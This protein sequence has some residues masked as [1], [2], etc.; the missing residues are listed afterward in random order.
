[1]VALPINAGAAEREAWRWTQNSHSVS[2]FRNYLARFP[3]GKHAGDAKEKIDR[4]YAEAIQAYKTKAL[5]ADPKAIAAM[6]KVVNAL[7]DSNAKRIKITYE[8]SVD[9]ASLKGL[10]PKE[11]GDVIPPDQAFDASHNKTRESSI[12]KSLRD[13]FR[14]VFS[15]DI[16]DFDDGSYI[17]DYGYDEYGRYGRLKD[18]KS[19]V[20]FHIKYVVS[21]SGTLYES[22]TGKKK[23]LYGILFGWNFA[24]KIGEASDVYD[25]ATPSAPAKNIRYTTYGDYEANSDIIPYTKMAESAFDDF[26]RKLAES[27]GVKVPAPSDSYGGGYGGYG[28]YGSGGYG[29]YG[30]SKYG[31]SGGYGSKYGSG[32]TKL[33]PEVQRILDEAMR[34]AR[35]GRY[36][37]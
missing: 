27:F 35:E 16:V 13:A 8:G 23:R 14:Q 20:T 30:S 19:P 22:T 29:G 31:G 11:Y 10:D 25:V 17:S 15:S 21:P 28:K 7:K 32:S 36:N 9:F 34:K 24:I 37:K 6:E 26:G 3:K 4:L 2:D 12:T 33:D 18:Q 5:N 1:M